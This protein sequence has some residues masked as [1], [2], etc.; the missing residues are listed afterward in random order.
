MLSHHQDG[1]GPIA[2]GVFRW[3]VT[4]HQTMTQSA[5]VAFVVPYFGTWPAWS[6]L[7]FLSCG[8]NEIANVLVLSENAP[9]FALPDNV[10]VI[11][12]PR[13]EIVSRLAKATGLKLSDF[14]GHKLCDFRPFFGLAFAD[15]LSSYEFWGFCDVDVMWGDLKKLLTPDFFESTD[16]FSAHAQFF[17]GHFTILRNAVA[18]NNVGFKMEGWRERCLA[19]ATLLVEERLLPRAV[20]SDRTLRLQ[21]SKSL[22][23]ELNAAF[24]RVGVTFDFKGDVAYLVEPDTPVVRWE[25]GS[26][27]YTSIAG[28]TTEVLYVHFM[29]LKHWWHWCLFKSDAAGNECHFFSRIGY[30]GAKTPSALRQF[31]WQQFFWLQ[32][33]LGNFKRISG[34]LLRQVLPVEI[35]LRLRRAL[36]GHNR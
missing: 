17:V 24:G 1:R 2:G 15:L 16:V 13:P 29:G 9:P 6:E 27:Y 14:S 34:C 21:R 32:S 3:V 25:N 8:K 18:A 30:G 7:F 26:I 19:P 22:P 35:F 23:E 28:K 31:P 10:K 4:G 33:I 12:M 11:P 5:K 36:I 20:E